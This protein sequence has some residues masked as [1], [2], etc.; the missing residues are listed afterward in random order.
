VSDHFYPTGR[1]KYFACDFVRLLAFE[2]V[3]NELGGPQA[4]WLLTVVVMVED[5]LRYSRSVTFSNEQLV[6]MAGFGSVSSLDRARK[7]CVD[8]GWLRYKPGGRRMGPG[9]YW[10]TVPESY[11][12]HLKTPL[13]TEC[14][15]RTGDEQTGSKPGGCS[16]EADSCSSPVTS[17]P[18]ANR[19]QSDEQTGTL[20]TVPVSD[21]EPVIHT[22]P[23]D[24][25]ESVKA[26]AQKT[27]PKKPKP[28]DDDLQFVQFYTAYPLHEA[29]SAALKAWQKISPDAGLFA[30]IMTGLA[31]YKASKPDWKNW[32]H[33]ATWLNQRR[34]TDETSPTST[35]NATPAARVGAGTPGSGHR[36]PAEPGQYH[37][38]DDADEGVQVIGPKRPGPFGPSESPTDPRRDEPQAA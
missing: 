2:D 20:L 3:A 14:L 17:K 26:P 30:T 33:P 16:A 13:Q 6:R 24:A 4:V 36:V 19:E 37:T 31:R 28:G 8:A 12:E 35:P 15:V 32:A 27:K 9:T 23:A 11:R 21:P 1:P 38:A 29:R 34:W 25:G 22:P 18:G 10:V 5:Q 7:K